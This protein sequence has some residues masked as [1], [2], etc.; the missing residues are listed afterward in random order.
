MASACTAPASF[1]AGTSAPAR[2]CRS[3]PPAYTLLDLAE[4]VGEREL[5]RAFD[6]A[7]VQRLVRLSEIAEL[8]QRTKGRV[9]GPLL[10]ALLEREGGPTRTRSEAEERFLALIRRAQLPEPEVNVRIHGYEVDFYWRS[11]GLVVEIDGFR[12]HSTRRAFE[13]DR[14][15]DATLRAAGLAAMRVTWNQMDREPYAVVARLAQALANA[16]A[17]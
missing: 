16:S 3:P 8:V 15:K 9:G 11:R 10:A 13:H 2:D 7:L 1:T 12:F 14:R 17:R 4:A 5:E 6:E